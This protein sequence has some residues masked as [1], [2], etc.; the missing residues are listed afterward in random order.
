MMKTMRKKHE[1]ED[2][3]DEYFSK[4]AMNLG[5]VQKMKDS[6]CNLP[7]LLE[8]RKDN[9]TQKAWIHSLFIEDEFMVYIQAL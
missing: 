8:N 5:N 1:I 6:K 2:L 4:S 3:E 7:T 9:P